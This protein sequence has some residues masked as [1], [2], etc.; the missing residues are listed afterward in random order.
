LAKSQQI[1]ALPVIVLYEN[2]LQTKVIKKELNE[3]E[4]IELI[5]IKP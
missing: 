1:E 5:N 4:F 2:G 3:T